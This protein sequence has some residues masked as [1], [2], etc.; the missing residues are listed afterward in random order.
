MD[1]PH[2]SVG[3]ER[4]FLIDA[5]GVQHATHQGAR[6]DHDKEG[7]NADHERLQPPRVEKTRQHTRVVRDMPPVSHESQMEET[8]YQQLLQGFL[9]SKTSCSEAR[10]VDE[11][12]HELFNYKSLFQFP[13]QGLRCWARLD[14]AMTTPRATVSSGPPTSS[15]KWRRTTDVHSGELIFE[16]PLIDDEANQECFHFE[17]PR[18]CITELW[19]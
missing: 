13:S 9:P 2:D 12:T 1:V 11:N 16:G 10:K 19:H 8:R 14:Y 15:I 4:S 6:H 5:L 18:D 17:V 7:T 3:H